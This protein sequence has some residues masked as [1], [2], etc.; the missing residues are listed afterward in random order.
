MT[1]NTS[2]RA[3]CTTSR[4]AVGA[5]AI[6]ATYSGDS[7]FTVATAGTAS[8]TVNALAATLG[9]SASPSSSTSVNTA[10]TFTAQLAGVALTSVTPSGTVTF[11]VNGSSSPDC[12]DMQVNTSGRATCTTSSLAAGSDPIAATYSGD[13]NF[14]VA[15]AGTMTQTVT[16]TTATTAAI[17][18]LN[19]S[20]SSQTVSLSAR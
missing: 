15:A 9:V 3:T 7:N 5:N 4:L 16:A 8:H 10:V 11:E 17:A 6:I 14:T 19:Y 12:P 2:G 20:P 13:S 1:V 18:S